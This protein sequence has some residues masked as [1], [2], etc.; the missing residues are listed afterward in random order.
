MKT[1][2]CIAVNILFSASCCSQVDIEHLFSLSLEEILTIQVTGSTLTDESLKTVPAAVSVFHHEQIQRMGLDYLY[3]LVNLV[4]GFQSQRSADSSLNFT[5]SSRG[6]RNEFQAKE[7]LVIM[8]GRRLNDPRTDSVNATL[9]LI[10]L[11]QVERV[12]IIRGPSSA[13]YGSSA[14]TG[15]INIITRQGVTQGSLSIGK[16][17]VR[18]YQF[19]SQQNNAW[20]LDVFAQA[21][22]DAGQHY[23]VDSTFSDG[24]ISTADPVQAGQFDMAITGENSVF[25]ASIRQANAQDFYLLDRLSNGFNHYIIQQSQLS[26][27]HDFIYKPVSSQLFLGLQQAQQEFRVQLTSAGDLAA[28]SLPSSQ[29]PW[30]SKGHFEG[31]S[32]QVKSHNDWSISAQNSLQFGIEYRRDQEERG[33]S[34]DNFNITKL[35]DNERPIDSYD[36]FIHTMKLG[37]EDSRDVWGS[38]IQYQQALGMNSQA[39]LGLR[40]DKYSNIDSHFSPRLSLVH[41]LNRQQTLKILY[42]EAFRAPSLN[43]TGLINNVILLGNP[44]LRHEVVKN[45][46]II[47]QGLWQHNSLSVGWFQ[48]EFTHPIVQVLMNNTVRTWGNGNTS[49]SQGVELEAQHQLNHQWLIRLGVTHLYVLPDTAFREASTLVSMVMNYEQ[50]RFNA[51]LSAVYHSSRDMLIPNDSAL[52]LDEYWQLNGKF[53]YSVNDEH[54]WFIQVKNLLNK[55]IFT[56]GQ[57]SIINHGIPNRGLE[58]SIGGLWRF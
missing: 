28:I 53:Q 5:F 49:W 18:A 6:R 25:R 40:F 12:E 36:G 48:S 16:G 8:D 35:F 46:D 14:F 7:I 24:Q 13:I 33:E 1:L 45:W 11:E 19:Y 50:A 34:E 43:E 57:G 54:E 58:L 51:N 4:P 10:L 9:P 29:E 47:W 41:Q 32:L 39:L 31:R 26:V 38:Y 23:R 30:L 3:E 20:Q 44:D 15:V 21:Q 56:A 42:G 37:T 22:Q 2:L 55:D 27:Q 17:L 52:S